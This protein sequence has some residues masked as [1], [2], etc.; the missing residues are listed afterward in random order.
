LGRAIRSGVTVLAMAGVLAA[1]FSC[2]TVIPGGSED[3]VGIIFVSPDG[4]PGDNPRSADAAD[5]GCRGS[6]CAA[7]DGA[8]IPGPDSSDDGRSV[9]GPLPT[10]GNGTCQA[11]EAC[12][13]CPQDC[14]DCP[15][16]TDPPGGRTNFVVALGKLHSGENNNDWV[17]TGTYVFNPGNHTVDA[18]LWKWSQ[19]S[20]TYREHSGLT[21]NGTCAGGS[22]K[23]RVCEVLTPEGFR[24]PPNDLR[25]GGYEVKVDGGSNAPYVRIQWAPDWYEEW[26]LPVAGSETYAVLRLKDSDKATVAFA[27]GSLASLSERRAYVTIV[28]KD[29]QTME[30]WVRRRAC[31]DC[32]SA[33]VEKSINATNHFKNWTVCGD[34]LSYVMT[35]LDPESSDNCGGSADSSIQYYMFRPKVDSRRDGWWFWHTCHTEG[36]GWNECYGCN[37]S[38]RHG[39][40]HIYAL[41]QVLDD[42]GSYVGHI[43]VEAGFHEGSCGNPTQNRF[44]DMLGVARIT[45][46]TEYLNNPAVMP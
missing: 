7:T 26:W 21:P 19:S 34:G 11:W 43:G 23:V 41:M 46:E 16:P 40:S 6:G 10:Y 29:G 15:L 32:Q 17:R 3:E 42:S 13:S 27:Y 37:N 30:K 25:T 31:S 22:G 4:T 8:V 39:G 38:N 1:G 24:D 12:G 14:G 18:A 20:P 28:E 33:V 35:W 44:S 2:E 9:D 45:P 36:G 5:S